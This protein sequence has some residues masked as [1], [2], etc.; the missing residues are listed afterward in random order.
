MCRR[1]IMNLNRVQDADV[2]SSQLLERSNS[3][4][5]NAAMVL[6]NQNTSFRDKLRSKLMLTGVDGLSYSQLVK[7]G[8]VAAAVMPENELEGTYANGIA[9]YEQGAWT[10]DDVKRSKRRKSVDLLKQHFPL[11]TSSRMSSHTEDDEGDTVESSLI[12]R[13]RKGAL[14]INVPDLVT[15]PRG[16]GRPPKNS[17]PPMSL[18][19]MGPPT[20]ETPW[21]TSARNSLLYEGLVRYLI[22][23]F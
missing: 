18:G 23:E 7:Q 2:D 13:R 17:L 15:R 20:L 10:S 14:Q 5:R 12:K 8:H 6:S 19:S 16:R 1:L 11:A 3:P 22:S 4:R 9:V 21:A